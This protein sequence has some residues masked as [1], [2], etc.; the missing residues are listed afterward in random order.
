MISKSTSIA[1]DVASAAELSVAVSVCVVPI[2]LF[3][4]SGVTCSVRVPWLATATPAIGTTSATIV[5]R[6][7]EST[8]ERLVSRGIR[9]SER[10]I[11]SSLPAALG[12][13]PLD[14]RKRK[15]RL[16]STI[17]ERAS[18]RKVALVFV[19]RVIGVSDPLQAQGWNLTLP[20]MLCSND[21]VSSINEGS[22][23]AITS[24]NPS[25]TSIDVCTYTIR[26]L[27]AAPSNST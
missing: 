26:T 14:E 17:R 27:S 12:R 19:T 22:V 16:L 23:Q 10:R 5:T 20:L 8:R 11:P 4:V 1:P 6:A 9:V 7:V 18:P 24:T 2:G 13:E 15:P 3:D 25:G 21:L